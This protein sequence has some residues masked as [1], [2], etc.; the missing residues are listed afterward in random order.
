METL[1]A[2]KNNIRSHIFKKKRG[3]G[4]KTED[5]EILKYIKKG[6]GLTLGVRLLRPVLRDGGE[7]SLK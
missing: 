6:E 1:G 4:S 7:N 3:E 2:H 5:S